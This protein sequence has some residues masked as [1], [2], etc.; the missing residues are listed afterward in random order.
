MLSP[1]KR[2]TQLLLLMYSLLY[3]GMR[4]PSQVKDVDVDIDKIRRVYHIAYY[5]DIIVLDPTDNIIS[6]PSRC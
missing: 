3:W 2:L 5:Y 6:P 4:M 1:R